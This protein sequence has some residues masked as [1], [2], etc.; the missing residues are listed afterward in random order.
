VRKK[1]GTLIV[2]EQMSNRADRKLIRRGFARSKQ[3]RNVRTSK[4]QP[5]GIA[6]GVVSDGFAVSFDQERPGCA[7]L[8]VY[9]LL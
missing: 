9:S 5:F 6:R 8:S 3:H 1:P 4:L 2:N 7:P